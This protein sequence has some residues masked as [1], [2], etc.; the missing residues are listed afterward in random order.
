MKSL[1]VLQNEMDLMNHIIEFLKKSN[2][3]YDTFDNKKFF[4]KNQMDVRI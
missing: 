2:L 4:I 3:D 1:G